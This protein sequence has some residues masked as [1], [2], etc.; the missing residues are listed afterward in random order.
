M[1]R[2]ADFIK[3]HKVVSI[4]IITF[5]GI[6]FLDS[7]INGDFTDFVYFV[8]SF[9][10]L[11]V[12]IYILFLMVSKKEYY[13]SKC[14]TKLKSKNSICPNCGSESTGDKVVEIKSKRIISKSK[15]FIHI[16]GSILFA[17]IAMS[18]LFFMV[19]AIFGA[20]S[21]SSLSISDTIFIFYT[22]ESFLPITIVLSLIGIILIV[23]GYL[24]KKKENDD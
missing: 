13:C 4:T 11:A 1:Q 5:L 24:F 6:V 7:L 3:R 15:L 21:S 8:K 14:N 22:N 12:M 19:A 2:F 16:G 23:I 20:L 18:F 9:I 17:P 10:Y